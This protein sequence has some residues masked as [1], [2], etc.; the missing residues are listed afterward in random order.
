MVKNPLNGYKS[1]PNLIK[2]ENL[3]KITSYKSSLSEIKGVTWNGIN[4]HQ[5]A[6]HYEKEIKKGCRLLVSLR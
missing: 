6:S 5:R 1:G 3:L 2:G 4:T